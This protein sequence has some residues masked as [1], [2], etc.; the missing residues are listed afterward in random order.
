MKAVGHAM[1][2]CGENSYALGPGG[3]SACPAAPVCMCKNSHDDGARARGSAEPDRR[4]WLCRAVGRR[5]A[6]SETGL[7]ISGRGVRVR[8]RLAGSSAHALA[9]CSAFCLFFHRAALERNTS[10]GILAELRGCGQV[11]G[12]NVAADIK[13]LRFT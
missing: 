7:C 5:R 6:G 8:M 11:P 12:S 13:D 9:R 10:R 1:W 2:N 3:A 4:V